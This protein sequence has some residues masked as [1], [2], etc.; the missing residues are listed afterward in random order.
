M[1]KKIF[2]VVIL[3]IATVLTAA[4]Q[5]AAKKPV[6]SD[7]FTQVKRIGNLKVWDDNIFFTISQPDK[8]QNSYSSALYQWI[9]NEPVRI[10]KGVSDYFFEDNGIIFRETRRET[11]PNERS[12]E[13]AGKETPATAFLKLS[14]G[15]GEAREWVKLPFQAGQIEW[16]EKDVVFYTSSYNRNPDKS[17]NYHIYDE[18]P[19]W[20][21]GRGDVS[22][23]RSHLYFY[24]KGQS[25]LL[26]DTLASVSGIK[27]SPD[28]KTLVYT[29]KPA[30]Y[31]KQ[32]EGNVLISLDVASLEKKEWNLFNQASYGGAVF[33]NNDEIVLTVN[34]SQ[35][36]DRIENS[37]IYRLN[38]R[39]GKQTLVDDGALYSFGNSIG[40]DVGGGG[41]AEI[42]FDNKGL[43]F[44]I[45]DVDY[46]PLVHLAWDGSGITPLTKGRL[47]VQE[48]QPY[49]DGFLAVA[50]EE[51]QGAEIYFIDKKGNASPLTAIN[52]PV[53]DE[54]NIVKPIEIKYT[55]P[56][57]RELN[58]YVLPPADYEKGKKYPAILDIHGGPKSAYGTVFFHEMQY[59][60]NE[61]YAV[62][63]TNP[64][65][66]SGR[67]SEFSD[68]RGQV[69]TT[70][71]NDLIAFTDAVLAQ[72][73][74][75]DADRL[76]VTGGSYG[77][78]LTNW[79][80]G[81]TGRFKAAVSQ[82]GISSWLSFSNTSDIGYSFTYTYWGTD[83]WKNG[84]RLW[85]ASPLKYADRV[86]TPTLFIHSAQDYRCWLVE[87]LQLYYALQ[88]FGVPSR[89]VVFENENHEL[90]RSGKPQNRIKRLEEIKGW[91]DKYLK[92]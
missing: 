41:R 60:A 86:Q 36:H 17:R 34:R 47:S 88:Y 40:S 74:F 50:L 53:F 63:F 89:L 65:G 5:S 30:W 71:Y 49:K 14:Y 73:D 38:L 39:T 2:L 57:G 70:D 69:G 27:L 16:I 61:G 4:A 75:I 37:S 42:T 29:L 76:G 84:Q 90:S 11:A 10:A 91:F 33:L 54:Y 72:T 26:S 67:G 7:F 66:S 59:W 62:F 24:N 22:G 87:G 32:P 15:Y 8:E 81:Q 43:R 52:K 9:D 3:S 56:A 35:E 92:N 28:K 31:G 18:L 48:Y 6:E 25:T 80:I 51:Q 20:S 79:I 45:T 82:R 44:V 46:A 58:G 68:I 83:I 55:T 23:R 64:T 77:G 21:N 13:T 19:F 85:D 78:L 12:G 1:G